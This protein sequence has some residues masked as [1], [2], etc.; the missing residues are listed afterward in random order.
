MKYM[1]ENSK[2]LMQNSLK[3]TGR[4]Q[5]KFSDTLRR[6]AVMGTN[7]TRVTDRNRTGTVVCAQTLYCSK[8]FTLVGNREASSAVLFSSQVC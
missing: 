8:E 3:E 7:K 1:R 5:G 4:G 6:M 2:S